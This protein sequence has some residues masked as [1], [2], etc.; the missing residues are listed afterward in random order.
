MRAVHI[1]GVHSII[2]ISDRPTYVDAK[3]IEPSSL[4]CK[5]SA[6]PLSYAP[7]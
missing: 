6:L 2:P 4:G 7:L 5:P 3:G 1:L